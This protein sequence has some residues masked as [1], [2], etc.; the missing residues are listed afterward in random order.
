MF[1]L[2]Q[3]SVRAV[4]ILA[5]AIVFAVVVSEAILVLQLRAR[6][7]SHAQ[8]ETI[9]LVNM[10]MEE[11]Q[12]NLDSA[13]QVL[14]A[15]Q[16]RLSNAY[17][18]Q[19]ELDSEATHLLLRA[20]AA[21]MNQVRALF[22]VDTNG[23]VVNNSVARV[24][25]LQSVQDRAYY[26]AFSKFDSDTFY[27]DIPVRGKKSNQW[28]I[29]LARRLNDSGGRFRGVI[30]A[31]LSIPRFEQLYEVVRLDYLRPMALYT[32]E[33]T[34]VASLPH[35]EAMI[36]SFASELMG[37]KLP[38]KAGDIQTLRRRNGEGGQEMVV[39]GHLLKYPMLIG[40][41]DDEVQSLASWRETSV[42][43]VIGASL[44]VVFTV[45]VALF[46]MRRLSLHED[47]ARALLLAS[48]RYQHTVDSVMD[49]IVAVDQAMNILLFNTAAERMFGYSAAQAI[50]QPLDI[51]IPERFRT[52]HQSHMHFVSNSEVEQFNGERKFDAVGLRADQ[53]EFPFESSI[54]RTIIGGQVQ[55]T[56]VLR[57]VT[58]Q[59]LADAELRQANTQLR[60]LSAS[61]QQVREEERTRISRELH[62][63]LG[64]QLT[65]LKLQLSWLGSRVR[66]GRAATVDTI[67]VMRHLLDI[68]ITAVRRIST[69]LRPP[70]LDDLGFA[71]AVTWHTSEVANRSGL[72]I[73]LMLLAD[74]QVQSVE[75][76]T[77]LFRI[78]QESLTNIVRHAAA[79]LVTIKLVSTTDG[80]RLI[81][82]DNGQGFDSR[83]S[84][85]GI[86]LVSMRERANAIGAHF[87]ITSGHGEGTVIEVV[88]PLNNLPASGE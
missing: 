64:Q 19:F 86:G 14:L 68:A 13:D 39:V 26:K 16:E 36:G 7:L 18:R 58:V 34:L 25:E 33:G 17:G 78:V 83:V 59:R 15:V 61:L 85:S 3:R 87:R 10:L 84:K 31:S 70:I 56:S 32:A 74:K 1:M 47:M 5:A 76:A 40:V 2:S 24:T 37:V 51:L 8:L 69:E 62:D 66:E 30:V 60:G 63:E 29:H 43:I 21:G 71:E 81:I 45:V 67:D 27:V 55:M 9:S 44:M 77:A 22:I 42:P 38:Q 20:R 11:T 4:A 82:D 54:S 52:S 12:Q 88:I 79:T 75:L 41:T 65:G 35:R 53:S 23:M 72:K 73:E 57:D 50:G 6:E 80:L 28:S 49:A 48:Q 46:L